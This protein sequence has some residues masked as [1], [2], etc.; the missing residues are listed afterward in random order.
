MQLRQAQ[1]V[2]TQVFALARPQTVLQA[3][4][5][6]SAAVNLLPAMSSRRKLR[7][8]TFHGTPC[9][10]RFAPSPPASRARC[11]PFRLPAALPQGQRPQ[12]ASCLACACLPAACTPRQHLNCD[13]LRCMQPAGMARASSTCSGQQ[14]CL[15]RT[16]LRGH[17]ASPACLP[18]ASIASQECHGPTACRLGNVRAHCLQCS[19]SSSAPGR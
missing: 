3:E 18:A 7:A 9:Q 8:C 5:S 16:I 17:A 2:A 10:H 13:L 14:L 15:L 11:T 12:Q 19:L 1:H 4:H 6:E